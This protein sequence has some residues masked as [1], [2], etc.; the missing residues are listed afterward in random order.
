AIFEVMTVNDAIHELIVK[1][2]P[3]KEIRQLAIEQGMRT[4]QQ[5][6]WEQVKRGKTSLSEIMRYAELGSEQ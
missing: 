2:A 4:L 6:G 5:C 1:R 3:A